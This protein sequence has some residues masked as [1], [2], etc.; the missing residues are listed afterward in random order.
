MDSEEEVAELGREI[1][2]VY[3]ANETINR[4]I[5]E[6]YIENAPSGAYFQQITANDN[7]VIARIK[8]ESG[9]TVCNISIDAS[10][11]LGKVYTIEPFNDS[12]VKGYIIFKATGSYANMTETLLQDAVSLYRNPIISA[13]ID[14]YSVGGKRIEDSAIITRHINNSAITDDKLNV[15]SVTEEKILNGAVT[16]N[17]LASKSVTAPKLAD[18]AVIE[19]KI[20]D[21]AITI[22]KLSVGI[23]RKIKQYVNDDEIE[24]TIVELYGNFPTNSVITYYV[25]TATSVDIRIKETAESAASIA[26]LV[27]SSL[28]PNKVYE[29]PEN[30][31]SGYHGYIVF[32]STPLSKVSA[33]ATLKAT[34]SD[35]AQSPFIYSTLNELKQ[36]KMYANKPN[37]TEAEIILKNYK[38]NVDLIYLMRQQNVN[39]LMDFFVFAIKQNTTGIVSNNANN[40][41]QI[42]ASQ[43]DWVSAWFVK[44]I[45]NADGDLQVPQD[46]F[47]IPTG[48]WH[49]YNGATTNVSRTARTLW[50]KMFADGVEVTTGTGAYCNQISLQWC[51]RVQACNTEKA[52][53]GG[54]EVIEEIVTVTFDE[55][56]KAKV[57]VIATML[58][59]VLVQHHYGLNAFNNVDGDGGVVHFVGDTP[60]AIPASGTTAQST[61]KH[62]CREIR[63]IGNNNTFVLGVNDSF[64]LDKVEYNAQYVGATMQKGMFLCLY[65]PDNEPIRINQG[66]KVFVDGFLDI[67][68]TEK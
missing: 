49:G 54:R 21:E 66:Q 52:D 8:N 2:K 30:N 32:N 19:N 63:Y 41:T 58:E 15:S 34:V 62:S 61:D 53:G 17:K 27:L 13:Y 11:K 39:M 37:S 51:N 38:T 9:T 42:N 6:L 22:N 3:V 23:R 7:N 67:Y 68:P 64:K 55:G 50:W 45:N 20:Q 35:I 48:G 26:R 46:T 33:S 36:F 16:A 18:G 1:N 65:T 28:K 56:M 44:A 24:N 4:L 59:D 43:S 5:Q 12:N 14:G 40:R 60:N 47:G 25:K 29:I 10:V 31:G 57:R